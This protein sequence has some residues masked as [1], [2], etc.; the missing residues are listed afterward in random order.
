M[1]KL[2]CVKMYLGLNVFY[3]YMLMFELEN[4]EG[5]GF[6]EWFERVGLNIFL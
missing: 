2:F 6:L 4:Y 3:W 1:E 5:V